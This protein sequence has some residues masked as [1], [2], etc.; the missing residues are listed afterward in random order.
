MPSPDPLASLNQEQR[1][2]VL[3]TDGPLM[4]IAGPG[5]GKTRVIIHRIARLINRLKVPPGS[6]MAV[7]FTNRAAA[8]LVERLEQAVPPAAARAAQVSNF[9]RFCGQLNRRFGPAIGLNPEYTIYDHDDQLTVVRRAMEASGQEPANAGL[10]PSDVLASISRAKSLLLTPEQYPQWL[11]DNEPETHP[12]HQ[13]AAAAY[14]HY[15]RELDMSNA[16]D[17]DD[18]IMRSVR[19][20]QEAPHVR[21]LLHRRIRYVMID[22]YQDTNHAQHEFTRLITGPHR[23][24]CVVGDPNQSIYAWRNA[25]IR[26]ILDFPRQ[27]PGAEVIRLGRNYRSSE[28]IVQAAAALISHNET[29][30]DNPLTAMDRE[31]PLIRVAAT[32]D[33]DSQASW[34]LQNLR[35]LVGNNLC[36]WNDCAVMYRTNAQSRP[37]EELC[38]SNRIPYRIIGGVRFYQRKEIKDILSYLRIIHNPGDSVS[39]QR[40][41]NTPPRSIGAVT[42]QRILE[43]SDQRSLTMMQGV[44]AAAAQPAAADRPALNERPTAA[45]ARFVQLSD[46]IGQAAQEISLA[47]LIDRI[48]DDTG[49]RDYIKGEENAA[50]RWENVMELRSSADRPEYACQTARDSLPAFLEHVSLFTE[51]DDY[52]P[53]EDALTLITMHQAKGLEFEAVALPGMT[54][55]LIPHSRADDV[56]EER[57][58]CYVAVTRAKTHLM[59]SWPE[60]S[61]QYGRF[62]PN[63]PSRFLE[64]L[65]QERLL[66]ETHP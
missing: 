66:H 48:I 10:R 3:T 19:I 36:A 40:I 4:V 39:L 20:L 42:I 44:R 55:G 65:P 59:L 14:P 31:G 13:A 47:Q 50:E 7:T 46:S 61:Y 11:Q 9:H 21:D 25:L 45:V 60:T 63:F 26:N 18:I 37:F 43:F 38:I 27:Y 23:N 58:L 35:R 32:Q 57:R 6:I 64:E 17:F 41:I 51:T 56:E 15:Q 62:Q 22:E 52:D 2:A 54:D 28:N 34:N 1:Q 5:S 24:L 8:E 16:L 49:L 30:I 29:R 53:T 12:N 33:D